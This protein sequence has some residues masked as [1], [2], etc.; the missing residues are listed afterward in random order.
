M[1]KIDLDSNK[2]ATKRGWSCF[3]SFH[4]QFIMKKKKEGN[5]A[6]EFHVYVTYLT[7]SIK[8]RFQLNFFQYWNQIRERP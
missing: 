6:E 8:N 7:H 5:R 3:S 4:Q 2:T 1:K